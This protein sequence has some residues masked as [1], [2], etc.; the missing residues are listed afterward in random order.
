MHRNCELKNDAA[1]FCR[2]YQRGI[3]AKSLDGAA[4]RYYSQHNTR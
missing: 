4:L 2:M 1:F 3:R